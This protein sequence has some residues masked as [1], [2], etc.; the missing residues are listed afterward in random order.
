MN[1]VG[2]C[3]SHGGFSLLKPENIEHR[4]AHQDSVICKRAQRMAFDE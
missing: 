3:I 1:G 4:D 2:L